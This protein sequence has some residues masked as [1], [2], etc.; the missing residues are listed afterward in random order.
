MDKFETHHVADAMDLDV[1]LRSVAGGEVLGHARTSY[2][3]AVVE[4]GIAL[5]RIEEYGV[6]KQVIS[7]RVSNDLRETTP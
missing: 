4:C 1:F 3:M 7:N 2:G 6:L 5:R